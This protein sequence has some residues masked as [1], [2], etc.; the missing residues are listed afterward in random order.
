MPYYSYNSP[1]VSFGGPITKSIRTLIAINV[2]VFVLQWLTRAAG[3][4]FIEAYFG[5][6]PWRI[7]HEF[8]IW[9]FVSYMFLHDTHQLMHIFINMLTLYMFGNDLERAWGSKRFLTY[10]FVTGIGAGFCSFLLGVNSPTATIGASGAIYGLLL[11][12]GLLYPNRLVYLYFL[13]PIKVKWF[14]LFMG[15]LAF[16]FSVTGS[17]QGVSNIAHL[18]GILVGLVFLKGGAWIQRFQLYHA[19]R[20]REELKRQFEVYYGEVRR[21][22]DDK[23]KTTIH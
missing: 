20:K 16:L 12:Y 8:M 6:I 14:V 19:H 13:F 1:S 18:G 9:Q 22:I 2:L 10:Y 5:L 21:K 11:A 23:N 7:T 15:G 3:S 17:E 4:S